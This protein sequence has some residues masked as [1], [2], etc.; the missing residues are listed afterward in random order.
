MKRYIILLLL[1]T[2]VQMSLFAQGIPARPSNYTPINDFAGILKNNE[3][4]ILNNQLRKYEKESSAQ[5]AVVTIT[6][7]GGKTVEN[8]ANELFNQ[9]GIGQK[10]ADNGILLLIAKNDRKM[11]IETG[12]GVEAYMT[13]A[14][15]ARIIDNVLTPHFK[16]A[17]F[18]AGIELAVGEILKKLGVAEFEPLLADPY[19]MA[20]EPISKRTKIP[21]SWVWMIFILGGILQGVIG[22]Y[23]TWKKEDGMYFFLVNI[24]YVVIVI[25]LLTVAAEEKDIWSR[26]YLPLG[27]TAAAI[28]IYLI[29]LLPKSVGTIVGKIFLGIFALL[30]STLPAAFAMGLASLISENDWFLVIVFFLTLGIFFYLFITGKIDMSGSG[31]SSYS[32]SSYSS[33]G[34]SYSSSYSDSSSWGGGSSGGGGASGSW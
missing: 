30:M 18:G 12:Y 23:L 21:F 26:V 29:I 3:V 1:A 6:S 9:W 14:E 34:S 4:Q 19:S 32:S 27:L 17:E 15:A 24:F 16:R 11:R 33:G 25:I 5:I 8:Y 28:L 22:Y 31:G 10:G 20:D 2:V 7:L 13:D